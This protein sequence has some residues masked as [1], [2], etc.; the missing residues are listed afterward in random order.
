MAHNEEA[1]TTR[2]LSSK[3]TLKQKNKTKAVGGGI[4]PP[5]GS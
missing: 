2:A 5:R 1:L 3:E 4:E